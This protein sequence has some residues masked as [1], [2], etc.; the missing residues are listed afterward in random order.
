MA[1]RTFTQDVEFE[2]GV[3]WSRGQTVDLPYS[4]WSAICT[5]LGVTLP[6]ITYEAGEAEAKFAA[7]VAELEAEVKRLKAE[8][9]VLKGDAK[10]PAATKRKTKDTE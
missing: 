7:Q 10:Q 8:N 9:E 6:E 2:N 3:K 5:H 1:A 4:S